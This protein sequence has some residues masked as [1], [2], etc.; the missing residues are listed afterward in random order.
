MYDNYVNYG[1]LNNDMKHLTLDKN[2]DINQ[3][4]NSIKLSFRDQITDLYDY[5]NDNVIHK[6][7]SDKRILSI[8]D[9]KLHLCYNML[10]YFNSN[11]DQ[12]LNVTTKAVSVAATSTGSR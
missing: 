5:F 8:I 3:Y 1:I 7:Y 12:F 9:Y 4:L 11:Y 10:V 6:K 2:D